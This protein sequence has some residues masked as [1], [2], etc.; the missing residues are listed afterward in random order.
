MPDAEQIRDRLRSVLTP[1][2]GAIVKTC[3]V[4]VAGVGSKAI[5]RG[6]IPL[7]DVCPDLLVRRLRTLME[8][9]AFVEETLRLTGMSSLWRTD[10]FDPGMKRSVEWNGNPGGQSVEATGGVAN[11]PSLRIDGR[12]G[13]DDIKT[14]NQ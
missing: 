11:T 10:F 2:A 6:E 13:N 9:S 5:L 14:K 3:G 1:Y 4:E 12:K 8:T 7:L